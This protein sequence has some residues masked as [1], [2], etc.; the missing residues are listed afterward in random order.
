MKSKKSLTDYRLRICSTMHECCVCKQKIMLGDRYH[1]GG[2]GRRAHDYC[3]RK[4][5]NEQP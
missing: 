2:Y 4:Q 3:A 1:D 5:T